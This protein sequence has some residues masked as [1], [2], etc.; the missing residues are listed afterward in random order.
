MED[1]QYLSLV[2]VLSAFLVSWLLAREQE[3]PA[4]TK[5]VTQDRST[6]LEGPKPWPLLGNFVS[7]S[8]IL[9]NPDA[10]LRKFAQR[11]GPTAMMWL[12]SQ[13]VLV[14]NSAREAKELLDNVINHRPS[15]NNFRQ[16]AWPYRLLG[17]GVGPQ[18]RL[19][20]NI[21]HRLL[22][23]QQ[24]LKFRDYQDFESTV[25]LRDIL[26]DPKEFMAHSERFSISVMF[27]TIYGVRLA[28]L[29]HP[30]MT[31]FYKVWDEMLHYFQPGTLLID[32]FPILQR[33]PERFQPWIK[34]AA[35]LNQRESALHMAFLRTL[36]KQ[37]EAGTAPNCFGAEL[38]KIQKEENIND[39]QAIGILG[40]LIGAGADATSSI[41]QTFF[42]IMAMNP[43]ALHLAQEEL[44]RVVGPSRLPTWEDQPRLPYMRALIK[45]VHRWAPIGNLG[46]PHAT[47][48]EDSYQGA[49]VPR[50]T[51]VFPNLTVLNRDPEV[52]R[53]PYEFRPERFLQDNFHA[54]ASINHE[55]FRRR[56][57][58][59]YG[60]G[61]RVCQGIFV[62]EASLYITI[63]RL[64]WAFDITPQPGAAPL[65][66]DD[67][68]PG[69]LTKPNPYSVQ[70]SPRSD[71]VRDVIRSTAARMSTDVID[72][73]SVELLAGV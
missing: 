2:A 1:I 34:I 40:M 7:F 4:S 64:V 55:D 17:V 33:L 37:V 42:K 47:S 13:P 43:R 11:Y 72:F 24:S 61:R 26:T 57:H 35:K 58:F 69:L 45:E 63:S 8:K 5:Q 66:M 32:F 16:R 10:E 15:Q 36:H 65:D 49:R 27:C 67:K 14:I 54:A 9:R 50:G 48:D 62:A 22:G 59:H 3:K 12:G 31:A 18:F 29:T 23:Q 28:Q 25:M 51:I 53:D 38:M 44:D 68:T 6:H 41:L 21:Y 56:D 20:R 52:Y 73:D 30:I 71:E 39:D 19:L 70:I 60:F 46:V